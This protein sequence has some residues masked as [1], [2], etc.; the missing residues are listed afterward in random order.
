MVDLKYN[1]CSV[2]LTSLSEAWNSAFLF[3][4]NSVFC[5]GDYKFKSGSHEGRICSLL[6]IIKKIK[7]GVWGPLVQV[8]INPQ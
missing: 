4:K 6:F 1:Q 7:K 8:P 2:R 5:A 3:S